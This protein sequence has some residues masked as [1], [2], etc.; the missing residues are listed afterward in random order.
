MIVFGMNIVE[1]LK[2]RFQ[3]IEEGFLERSHMEEVGLT[4]DEEQAVTL[5]RACYTSVDAVDAPL[6]KA[7]EGF[8]NSNPVIFERTAMHLTALIGFGF[9]PANA[10]EFVQLLNDNMERKESVRRAVAAL[11]QQEHPIPMLTQG[12]Y[13][14]SR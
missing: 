3:L 5:L 6:M 1:D 10:T 14:E 12:A 9:S 8:L 13:I 2:S 7:A 4:D 11:N